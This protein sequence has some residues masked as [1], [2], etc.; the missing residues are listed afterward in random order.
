MKKKYSFEDYN[1]NNVL[2][3]SWPLK[4]V[5]LYAIKPYI[6]G[7]IPAVG[8]MMGGIGK[9]LMDL[10]PTATKDFAYQYFISHL[11]WTCLPA[12]VLVIVALK[13]N[14]PKA[15]QAGRFVR[16][17]WKNGREL[18]MFVFILEIAMIL[19]YLV[20]GLKKPDEVFL[21]V[22]YLDAMAI[23]FLVKSQR[24]REIFAEFP[25]PDDQAWLLA[26]QEHTILSYQMYL[27]SNAVKN[28]AEEAYMKM[29]ELAWEQA[30]TEDTAESYQRYVDMNIVTKR[31]AFEARQRMAELV[32]E[33]LQEEG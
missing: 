33:R 28:H 19:V 24:V 6:P 26:C 9:I 13:R 11:L 31:H 8:N 1:D 5:L 30:T 22:L 16:W 7:L 15:P 25:L 4:L 29:D 21:M 3:V 18:L 10:V 27:S 23:F 20:A 12:L 14:L 17:S 2:K 32:G